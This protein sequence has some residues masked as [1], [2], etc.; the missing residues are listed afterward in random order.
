VTAMG[1][2]STA[3]PWIAVG[4]AVAT[5]VALALTWD[6]LPGRRLRHALRTATVLGCLLGMLAVAGVFAN[7]ETSAFVTWGALF[8]T[9]RRSDPSVQPSTEPTA[10]AD[11]SPLVA[12]PP[13][14]VDPAEPA[15]PASAYKSRIVTYKT[16]V[17][18]S[19]FA[20]ET[21]A[22][23][24][25]VYDDPAYAQT[26][27][28][29]IEALH[30]FPGSPSVWREGLDVQG[31]LD[32]EIAEGRMAPTVVIFP[33]QTPEVK[34]DTECTDMTK[35][36]KAETYLTVDIPADARKRFRVRTDRAG[37]GLI[38]YSAGGFCA[39]NLILRHPDKY[40]A[41]VAMSAYTASG[42]KV[43]DGSE[44]THNHPM[45]RLE[46]LP[47]PP[48]SLYI[49]SARDD[50]QVMKDMSAFVEKAKAPLTVTTGLVDVGGHSRPV[51]RNL[52]PPS[53]DWLSARLARPITDP[54]LRP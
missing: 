18:A 20:M 46:H 28:P 9:E 42:I 25:L 34:T 30:G 17:G 48:V 1:P 35:G 37:W 13:G 27:F 54:N 41:S 33:W 5:V 26:R 29:V 7:R 3:V 19:G 49:S 22:Y 39:I 15:K 50:E 53:F 44:D 47:H 51:W 8:G 4:V 23:L 10:V 2:T 38:G 36:P 32:K 14:A 40:A 24:P 43:G 31:H 6:R 45:W 21:P 16:A 12:P 11:Q 52:S